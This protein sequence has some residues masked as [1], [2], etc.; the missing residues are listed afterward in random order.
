MVKTS[1][2]TQDH[3]LASIQITIKETP[4]DKISSRWCKTSNST[5]RL[6]IRQPSS[7]LEMQLQVASLQMAW[8]RWYSLGACPIPSVAFQACQEGLPQV[9]P[10][11]AT[12]CTPTASLE[13]V[14]ELEQASSKMAA[15]LNKLEALC[16]ESCLRIW[17]SWANSDC[18]KPLTQTSWTR[19]CKS[20]KELPWQACRACHLAWASSE[21]CH[22]ASHLTTCKLKATWWYLDSRQPMGFQI[23]QSPPSVPE[24]FQWSQVELGS[25]ACHKASTHLKWTHKLCWPCTR[26]NK[27]E[28]VRHRTSKSKQTDDLNTTTKPMA[29]D[30]CL[31]TKKNSCLIWICRKACKSSKWRSER[32]VASESKCLTWIWITWRVMI[33]SWAKNHLRISCNSLGK[34]FIILSKLRRP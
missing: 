26:A 30:Q 9:G 17:L 18:P 19:S 11:V 4:K 31:R 12:P 22:L 1:N 28:Q 10:P 21:G 24:V 29:V 25:Q 13:P 32:S 7:S 34:P 6:N 14:Q 27:S 16:Q 2:N 23:C 15:R 8:K 5:S 20:S 33:I 3:R